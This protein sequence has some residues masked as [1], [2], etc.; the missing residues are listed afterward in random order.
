MRVLLAAKNHHL[1]ISLELLVS[2]EPG[3]QVIGAV[4]ETEGL[5]A[6]IKSSQ[7][8]LVILDWDLPGRQLR[9]L[10]G[11]LRR[12][13]VASKFIVLGM[14]ADDRNIAMDA[15][16]HAFVLKAAP[17]EYLLNAIRRSNSILLQ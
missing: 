1:R 13:F 10:L 3:M 2:E 16:A 7:P 8:D 4:S 6:L 11:D 14:D 5:Q 15:G 17:P 9:E 12:Q